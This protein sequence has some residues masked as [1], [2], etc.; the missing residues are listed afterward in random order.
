MFC[1]AGGWNYMIVIELVKVRLRQLILHHHPYCDKTLGRILEIAWVILKPICPLVFF[2]PWC[3][4]VWLAWVFFS[5]SWWVSEIS[6]PT[7][8]DSYMYIRKSCNL[9]KS[10]PSDCSPQPLCSSLLFLT[11]GWSSKTDIKWTIINISLKC[12]HL[13]YIL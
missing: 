4:F 12:E 3:I 6:D 7:R 1:T 9:V 8:R 2:V 5:F 13:D 11:P 10:I